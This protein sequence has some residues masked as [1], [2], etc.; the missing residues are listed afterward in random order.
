MNIKTL[1]FI[2]QLLL[3]ETDKR[4]TIYT[5]ARDLQDQYEESETPDR[6]L[7][8][9]QCEAADKCMKE[10]FAALKP[11]RDFEEQEW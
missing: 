8:N 6:D 10:H 1:E 5:A 3:A 7:I 9:R 4:E 2:H 11:L